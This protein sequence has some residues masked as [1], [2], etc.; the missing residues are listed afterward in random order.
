MYAGFWRRLLAWILDYIVIILIIGLLA[1]VVSAAGNGQQAGLLILFASG[2]APWL[3]FALLESSRSQATLGKAALGIQVTDLKGERVRFGRATGRYFGK[4][5]SGLIFSI[6]F[7]MAG[8]T[9]RRQALHDKIADTLVVS[10][11]FTPAEIADAPPAPTP[12]FF[13]AVALGVFIFMFGSFGFGFV[14]AIAVPAY[15]D[16]TIRAQ[17]AEGLINAAPAKI[18]VADAL[19]EQGDLSQLQGSEAFA[20]NSRF[21]SAM[22]NHDGVLVITFGGQAHKNIA[23]HS[24]ELVPGILDAT[25]EIV[26]RCGYASGPAGAQFVSDPPGKL[27]TLPPKYLPTNCR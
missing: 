13:A 14:S 24:I 6:G 11:D 2:L 20:I 12:S 21:V 16:Y 17:V 27:T 26:W 19:A 3:Y 4:I 18:A 1:L 10:K 22:D 9:D 15:Q 8:F 5:L 7:A 25:D 23:N